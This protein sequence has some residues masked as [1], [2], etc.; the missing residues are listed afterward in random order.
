MWSNF[1]GKCRRQ[2]LLKEF[3]DPATLSDDINFVL[4]VV[5]YVKRKLKMNWILQTCK[6]N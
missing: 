4:N 3:Q 1:A 2:V 5:M 6:R